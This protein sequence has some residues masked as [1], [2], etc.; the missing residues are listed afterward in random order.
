M[1]IHVFAHFYI[2]LLLLSVLLLNE[3]LVY[4]DLIPYNT[5]VINQS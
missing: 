5:T 4:V 1:S 3:F 2:G